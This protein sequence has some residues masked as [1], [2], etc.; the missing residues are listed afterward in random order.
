MK[1][2]PLGFIRGSVS[3]RL[4]FYHWLLRHLESILQQP[5][6]NGA[7]VSLGKIT[8]IDKLVIDSRQLIDSTAK[9][10]ITNDIL[11]QEFVLSS[12]YPIIFYR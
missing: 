1:E 10:H 6:I 4:E 2:E 8:I 11:L 9:I 3:T 7:Q 5:F 12:T